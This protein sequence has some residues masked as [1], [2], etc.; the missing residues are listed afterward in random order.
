MDF[1]TSN[2]A[3][4]T[5]M[6]CTCCLLTTGADEPVGRVIGVDIA[7]M[8][9]VDGAT[10]LPESDFLSAA[11]RR[12]IEDELGGRRAD[13]LVSDMAPN[14]TGI[15]FMDHEIIMQLCY[16]ALEFSARVLRDGGTFLCKAW[17]GSEQKRFEETM[18]RLYTHVKVVKPQASR[19]DSS[20]VFLLARGFQ[21][22]KVPPTNPDSR[23]SAVGAQPVNM[24]SADT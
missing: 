5:Y 17:Q 8:M 2:N 14:A 4:A 10:I 18:Q 6:Q 22:D 11:T 20:E 24:K 23:V 21:R 3:L 1:F 15:R 13:V 12:R 7:H 19:T 9:P 16:A